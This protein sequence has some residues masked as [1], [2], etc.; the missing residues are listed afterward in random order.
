VIAAAFGIRKL[1]FC[2][3][4]EPNSV[5]SR[6]PWHGLSGAGSRQR[7]EPTGGCA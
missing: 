1:A 6:T 2:A 5:A 3:H 4:I 7:K